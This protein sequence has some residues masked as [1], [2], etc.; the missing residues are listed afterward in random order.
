MSGTSPQARI[1]EEDAYEVSSHIEK[2]KCT[3]SS[4]A[5]CKSRSMP[6]RVSTTVLSDSILN[7]PVDKEADIDDW[8]EISPGEEEPEDVE[9][10]K[11]KLTGESSVDDQA[12][13]EV[14]IPRSWQAG[15][16]SAEKRVVSPG[17]RST[18][19]GSS[20]PPSVN[21]RSKANNEKIER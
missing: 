4:S 13:P 20:T 18:P 17:Y 10:E 6:G 5:F 21:E 7:S 14:I 11:G 15:S 8:E 2:I 3:D 16:E 19:S 1:N 9:T 12:P